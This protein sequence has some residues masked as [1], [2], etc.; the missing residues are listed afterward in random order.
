M[1]AQEVEREL[2]AVLHRHAEDAMNQTDTQQ[3]LLK[4]EAEAKE[5]SRR[6]R[7]RRTVG[8]VAAAA[9]AAGA[10]FAL[11]SVDPGD[12][13][14]SGPAGQPQSPTEKV[15][16]RFVESF[17][18]G[19][20]GGVRSL[21][22][23]GAMADWRERLRVNAAWDVQYLFEPCAETGATADGTTV[24]CLFDLNLLHSEQVGRGPYPNNV[25]T[26]VVKEG[27]VVSAVEHDQSGPGSPD[28]MYAAVARWIQRN[29]PDDYQFMT[30]L[31]RV[32]PSQMERFDELWKKYSQDFADSSTE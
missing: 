17:A 8:G 25:F 7:H 9:V 30:H 5:V 6:D 4:F 11:W 27:R 18:S 12:R 2:T 20:V 23:P 28:D 13:A 19:D 3:E 10:G 26:L 15:A 32:R 22:A 31:D 14:D 24:G 16:Q 1:N 21:L 29:H